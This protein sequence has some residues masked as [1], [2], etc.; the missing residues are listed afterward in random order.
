MEVN[1]SSPFSSQIFSDSV[2]A[3]YCSRL[4]SP[5]VL[6]KLYA[7]EIRWHYSV[8]YYAET[9]GEE[10]LENFLSLISEDRIRTIMHMQ[11]RDEIQHVEL[12]RN[13]LASIGIDDRATY[14]GQAMRDFVI[15]LPTL[16]EKVFAFQIVIESISAAFCEWRKL[17]LDVPGLRDVDHQVLQDEKRHLKMGHC[18]L[19]ACDSE[20][21]Q[22][23][24][25]PQKQRT[26]IRTINEICR[27]TINDHLV[28]ALAPPDIKP[29]ITLKKTHL[30]SFVAKHLLAETSKVRT[31]L[32]KSK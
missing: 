28:D 16:S 22:I 21:W 11:M 3:Q 8:H 17:F 20:E 2:I 24:L 6:R 18:L 15:N 5:E 7:D 10:I 23:V 9:T 1:F 19:E 12:F 27:T 25:T 30:D 29:M 4:V 13:S 14:Y 26:I 31:Y 32:R